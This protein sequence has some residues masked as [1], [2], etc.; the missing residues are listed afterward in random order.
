VGLEKLQLDAVRESSPISNETTSGSLQELEIPEYTAAGVR[1][2]IT[3][4][5]YTLL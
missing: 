5:E 1:T 2:L 3:N 4:D